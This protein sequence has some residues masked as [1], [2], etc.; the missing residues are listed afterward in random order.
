MIIII[1]LLSSLGFTR[2]CRCEHVNV[3]RTTN[4]TR[5][6]GFGFPSISKLSFDL[7]VNYILITK[8]KPV[9]MGSSLTVDVEKPNAHKYSILR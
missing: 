2:S 9:I 1:S 7:F 6:I 4:A 5:A 3:K 8:I